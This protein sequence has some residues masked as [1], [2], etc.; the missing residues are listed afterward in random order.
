MSFMGKGVTK[1][2]VICL[3]HLSHEITAENK[4]KDFIT[5]WSLGN[6]AASEEATSSQLGLA[7]LIPL[8]VDRDQEVQIS[9]NYICVSTLYIYGFTQTY[10]S[11]LMSGEICQ[12]RFGCCSVLAAQRVP[13]SV[14]ML[15]EH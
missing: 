11:P 8:W 15:S 14:R 2:A 7:W 5:K 10:A 9:L 4:D 13:S 12:F 3:L 1:N 6:E